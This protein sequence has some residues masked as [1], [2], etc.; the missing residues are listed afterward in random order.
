MNDLLE[1]NL[2]RLEAPVARLIREAV[3]P[4][5]ARIVETRRGVPSLIFEGITLHSRIDPWGEAEKLAGS[6]QITDMKDRGVKPALFGFGLGYHVAALSE[7]FEELTVI[8]PRAWMARLAFSYN[9]LTG[10]LDRIRLMIEPDLLFAPWPRAELIPHAPSVRINRE[11]FAYWRAFFE[12][13]NPEELTVE[14]LANAWGEIPGSEILKDLG[15]A[16]WSGDPQDLA[17]AVR[18]GRGRRMNWKQLSVNGRNDHI[19]NRDPAGSNRGGKMIIAIDGQNIDATTVPGDNLE[20]ILVNLQKN[21]TPPNRAIVGVMLNGE[22]YREDV[23]HA[24]LE[25]SGMRSGT[26]R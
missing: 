18:T 17:R 19:I 26:W 13:R 3:P 23:P 5:Q 14:I 2:A 6:A 8:E 12:R 1:Q 4:E 9:D 21:N 16:D 20:E 10:I 24:A 22:N 11:A 25:V 15:P 7:A